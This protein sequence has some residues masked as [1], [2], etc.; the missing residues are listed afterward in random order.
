MHQAM[1]VKIF[2][3]SKRIK[4]CEIGGYVKISLTGTYDP[5]VSD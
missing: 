1:G 3:R 5:H 2:I 4:R